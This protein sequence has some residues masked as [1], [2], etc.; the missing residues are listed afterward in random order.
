MTLVRIAYSA[1]DP[2]R[3]T[4]PTAARTIAPGEPIYI[5]AL[6]AIVGGQSADGTPVVRAF[7]FMAAQPGEPILTTDNADSVWIVKTW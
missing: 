2:A 1:Y 5:D 3:H 7:A 6:A 4:L